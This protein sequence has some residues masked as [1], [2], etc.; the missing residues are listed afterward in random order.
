MHRE[1]LKAETALLSL[2]APVKE[3]SDRRRAK[4]ASGTTRRHVTRIM[5]ESDSL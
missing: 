1:E 5:V 2:R 3:G 4:L